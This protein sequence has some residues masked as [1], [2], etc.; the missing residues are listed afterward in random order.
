MNIAVDAM[1]GDYAPD[2]IVQGALSAYAELGVNVTLVGDQRGWGYLSW[3]LFSQGH[4]E[5]D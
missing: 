1:G 3:Q 5:C 2:A 4:K